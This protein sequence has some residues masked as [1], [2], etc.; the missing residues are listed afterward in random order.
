M[1]AKKTCP[2][3]ASFS[4]YAQRFEAGHDVEQFLVDATLAQTMECPVDVLQQFVD[5][6]VGA[7]HRRQAARVLARKG[8][9]ARPEKRNEEILADEDPQC[10]GVAAHDLGQVLRQPGKLGELASPDFVQR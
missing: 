3:C 2:S 5:V 8:L 1:I 6:F 4:I 9:G 7:L 10:L